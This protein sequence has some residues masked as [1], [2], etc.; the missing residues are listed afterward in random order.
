MNRFDESKDEW[1]L[2]QSSYLTNI[3]IIHNKVKFYVDNVRPV[4][5]IVTFNN[6]QVDI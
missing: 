1:M 2:L 3:H 6:V 4:L 5:L